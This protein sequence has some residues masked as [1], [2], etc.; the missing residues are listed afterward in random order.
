V[1]G[2]FRVLID[3]HWSNAHRQALQT[4][5]WEVVRVVD[6]DALGQGA[7]DASVPAYCAQHGH[8]WL[9]SDE[10]ARGDITDWINSGKT[11]PGVI[12]APQRRHV[13][14]RRLVAFFESLATEATP[15]AGVIRYV[16]AG[17]E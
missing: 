11:L 6:V 8:V 9:T 16:T 1:A 5:G 4:A 13:S 2:G 14:P 12:I 3:E 15:F 17:S 7:A 10:A